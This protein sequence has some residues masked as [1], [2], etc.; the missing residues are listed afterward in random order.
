MKTLK[1]ILLLLLLVALIAI[2]WYVFFSKKSNY[3]SVYLVPS[4]ALA[5]ATVPSPVASIKTITES[6]IWDYLKTNKNLNEFQQ[7]MYSLDSLLTKNKII[8][9]LVASRQLMFSVHPVKNETDILVI[10]DLKRLG[11]VKNIDNKLTQLLSKEDYRVS[12]R[13]Y[14]KHK[15]IELLSI[16]NSEMYYLSILKGKLLFSF[17]HS[18]IE[19]AIDEQNKMLLGRD[20][21]FIEV[22]KHLS[23]KGIVNAILPVQAWKNQ[24]NN[25][26]KSENTIVQETFDNV[27]F[28][29]VI[30]DIN[31]GNQLAL[32]TFANTNQHANIFINTLLEAG[33]GKLEI[34]Q[35][36][37]QRA[38]S[39]LSITFNDFSEFYADLISS[40]PDEQQQE[41]K[42][43]IEKVNKKLKIDINENLFGWIDNEIGFIQTQPSNLGKHNEFAF[44]LKATKAKHAK[45]NLQ[46]LNEQVKKNSP[47]KFRSII[48]N[49][50]EIHYLSFGPV[51]KTLFG[52][53]IKKL[54]KPYY[55]IIDKYVVFSNHPQTLKN[56]IDD[57]TQERT[58]EFDTEYYNFRKNYSGEANVFNYI[59]TEILYHNLQSMLPE[60]TW[61]V[62]KENKDYIVCFNEIGIE[63]KEIDDLLY[64][65]VL[66][67]FGGIT[68]VEEPVLYQKIEREPVGEIIQG[69]TE[70][71]EKLE[72]ES[73]DTLANYHF[74]IIINDLDSKQQKGYYDNGNI[75]YEADLKKGVLHGSYKEYH[76]N[77]ELRVKG[78]YNN[79]KKASLWRYYNNKGKLVLEKDYENE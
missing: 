11:N 49:E 75:K 8:I 66:A 63:T 59:N 32:K 78:K 41:T 65:E 33:T 22:N 46:F 70:V 50:H 15:I 67:N 76:E 64:T 21:E 53:L 56:I 54:E 2:A 68:E 19:Q 72:A 37:S 44:V 20:L 45:Q 14:N 57:F 55:T 16:E 62:V 35:V 26:F 74:Y 10:A 17:T 31:E 25:P 18:I 73:I 47:V 5:I 29:G 38:A 1:R 36:T 51:L 30:V 42:E 27:S 34:E 43:N 79:N 9:R 58:L 61:K 4:N 24:E 77:G 12:S 23:G 6:E 52:N 3:Q 39:M 69:T 13:E 7:Q 60:E 40:L 71:L 48:Y 28:M